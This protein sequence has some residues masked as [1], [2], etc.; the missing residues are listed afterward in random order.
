MNKKTAAQLLLSTIVVA[1]FLTIFLKYFNQET[2]LEKEKASEEISKILKKKSNIIKDIKY[3]SK[4]EA[5]NTYSIN[6]EYGEINEKESNIIFLKNV[7]ATISILNSDD[8]FIQS[9]FAKYNNKNYDTNFYENTKIEYS[10]HKINCRYLDLLFNKNL[11]ILYENIIYS[12]LQTRLLADRLEID[13]IT[14]NSK[15]SMK[16]RKEK[17]KIVYMK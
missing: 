11:A 3:F 4:D 1:I 14:K 17:I 10:E 6:A 13:I 2:K 16:D 12:H 15:L 8:I 9:D 5:G 7:N